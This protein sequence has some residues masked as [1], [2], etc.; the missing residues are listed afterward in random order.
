MGRG[1]LASSI[2]S[3]LWVGSLDAVDATAYP[4]GADKYCCYASASCSGRGYTKCGAGHCD[5]NPDCA[6]DNYCPWA[7]TWSSCSQNWLGFGQN[8]C[9]TKDWVCPARPSAPGGCTWSCGS[10]DCT[11]NGG[12]SCSE[13]YEVKV[14]T[15]TS[16]GGGKIYACCEIKDDEGGGSSSAGAAIGIVAAI[17]VVGIIVAVTVCVMKSKNNSEGGAQAPVPAVVA[18]V[19][20][21]S[22]NEVEL[23]DVKPTSPKFDPM[24]GEPVAAPSAPIG[25]KFD[26]QTGAPIPKFDPHTGKQNW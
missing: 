7:G 17:V 8:D 20:S 9:C 1:A 3:V 11:S 26:P 4:Y 18:A 24:T 13:G 12:K 5:V 14:I 22:V 6:G 2:F 19:P 10:S 23:G 25:A 15:S 21:V 16:C